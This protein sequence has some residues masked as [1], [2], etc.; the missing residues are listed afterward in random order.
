MAKGTFVLE[1]NEKSTSDLSKV[2]FNGGWVVG[3]EPT[4]F[5][6]TSRR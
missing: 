2:L 1:S 3:F 5:G 6:T 4:V